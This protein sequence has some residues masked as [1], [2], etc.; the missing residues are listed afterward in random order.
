M[1]KALLVV[2]VLALALTGAAYADV[3]GPRPMKADING[4]PT[5]AGSL[6]NEVTA[7]ANYLGV[8]EGAVYDIGRREFCNY[9]AATLYTVQNP[10]VPVAIDFGAVNTDGIALT[11]DANIGAAMPAQGVPIASALQYLY[12]GCGVLER[13]LAKSD[14]DPTTQWKTSFGVDVAFKGTF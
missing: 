11:A 8:R 9:A 2:L 5:D 4:V 3:F 6:L 7:A 12:V 14:T 1:N 10:V 13:N